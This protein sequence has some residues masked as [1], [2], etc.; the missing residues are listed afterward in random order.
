[1]EVNIGSNSIIDTPNILVV[2]GKPQMII[3]EG[4]ND[5]QALLTMNFYD[6]TGKHIAKLRR[7]SWVYND[8]NNYEITTNPT[9][10]KLVNKVTGEL[11]IEINVEGTSKIRISNA[12]IYTIQKQLIIVTPTELIIGGVIMGGNRI[13][14]CGA[15]IALG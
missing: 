9:S 4:V 1:M 12:K 10:L 6:E 11:L 15:G 13:V 5:L 7:N 14:N 3:E 2:N 8:K